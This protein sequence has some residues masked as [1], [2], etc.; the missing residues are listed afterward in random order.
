M[1]Q[2]ITNRIRCATCDGNGRICCVCGQPGHKCGCYAETIMRP[3]PACDITIR[4]A[5]R[6]LGREFAI[7]ALVLIAAALCLGIAL[8]AG[9]RPHNTNLTTTTTSTGETKSWK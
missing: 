5:V 9:S 4:E 7:Y 3:C 6:S 1:Q 8:G 2:Q